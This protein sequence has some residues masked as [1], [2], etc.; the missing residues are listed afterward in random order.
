MLDFGR[1]SMKRAS[2]PQWA[3]VL[4]NSLLV[5]MSDLLYQK[6][7]QL[8]KM[9][10][11]RSAQHMAWEQQLAIARDDAEKSR[12]QDMCFE[13]LNERL[14]NVCM[15]QFV[16]EPIDYMTKKSMISREGLSF[17]ARR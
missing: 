16:S 15:Y 8:E 17:K 1:P 12:R 4:S 2:F 9:A 10:A 13:S 6:Q 5:Q 11:E 7:S 14:D 3:D